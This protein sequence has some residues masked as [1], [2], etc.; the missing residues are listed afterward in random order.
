MFDL[1]INYDD[2]KSQICDN[3]MITNFLHQKRNFYLS[4]FNYLLL[5]YQNLAQN[6]DSENEI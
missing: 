6:V 4:F 5:A 2:N 1:K 3:M